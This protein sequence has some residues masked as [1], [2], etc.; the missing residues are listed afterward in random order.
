MNNRVLK[1]TPIFL[2]LVVFSYQIFNVKQHGLSPWRGGGFGMYTNFHPA[3]RFIRITFRLADNSS[4]S[5]TSYKGE[6][7]ALGFKTKLFPHPDNLDALI[8]KIK[9]LKWVYTDFNRNNIKG[10]SPWEQHPDVLNL[11]PS[12]IEI[13]ILEH[14][15]AN[16]LLALKNQTIKKY[17]QNW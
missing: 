4:Y 8:E 16:G 14:V 2:L 12:S 9:A 3:N 1:S 10:I 17:A 13:E 7:G 15:H 6:W 11:S 5:F